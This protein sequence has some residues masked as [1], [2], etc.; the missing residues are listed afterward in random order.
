[1]AFNFTVKWFL[2][3]MDFIKQMK[4]SFKKWK[5]NKKQ[6]AEVKAP[7]SDSFVLISLS[8][9]TSYATL[10]LGRKFARLMAEMTTY[11]RRR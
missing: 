10:D 5:K 9:I 1:M 6:A 3:L 11:R 8:G 7:R 4:T 2:F